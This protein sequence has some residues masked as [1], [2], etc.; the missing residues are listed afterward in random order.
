MD[1]P[2]VVSLR[3]LE[4]QN[5][6]TASYES[7]FMLFASLE[8]T[9]P[10]A[11][12]NNK[13]MDTNHCPV[14]CGVTC[15]GAA[16]LTKPTPAAY[17]IFPDLSV[18][19]EGWYRI[20]FHLFE[21]PKRREDFDHVRPSS[22]AASA[23]ED[24]GNSSAP[25]DQEMM[26]N[27]THVYSKPFQ[28]Y[29]A[30]KFPGLRES[31]EL[32]QIIADQGCRVRIRKEVRQRKCDTKAGKKEED[33]RSLR[34]ISQEG[35]GS[36]DG[37]L[38]YRQSESSEHRRPSVDSQASQSYGPS[39]QP[40]YPQTALPSP[41]TSGPPSHYTYQGRY[42]VNGRPAQ[43]V[44][45]PQ[46]TWNQAHY[47]SHMPPQHNNMGPPLPRVSYLPI[48]PSS[49]F[50]QPPRL[51]SIESLTNPAQPAKPEGGLYNVT[52][53][54]AKKRRNNGSSEERSVVLKDGDRPQSKTSLRKNG[55]FLQKHNVH[56]SP[57][58]CGSDVIE[59]DDDEGE[60][61]GEASDSDSYDEILAHRKPNIYK[62]ATGDMQRVPD[63]ASVA[64]YRSNAR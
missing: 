37:S 58:A 62:R 3:I 13:F 20:K 21:Q 26:V 25:N 34:A 2:P 61:Y 1:P 64:A 41:I 5:D 49:S 57:L 18:R 16:Y 15:A 30:K 47:P 36:I 55:Y 33:H 44:R 60:H 14:L 8:H 40:S 22:T 48:S 38:Y 27:M 42:D 24:M 35:F 45:E 12:G 32:S 6:V 51:P 7:T 52:S 43:Y 29:S 28:V 56:A 39:R 31:T 11:A 9:R 4:G 53:M 17:F 59:V 50:A 63:F 19:H 54:I 10:Y 23:F 46:D